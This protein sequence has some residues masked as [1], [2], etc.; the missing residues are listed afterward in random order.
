MVSSQG[1]VQDMLLVD[2]DV[3]IVCERFET[4]QGNGTGVR[5]GSWDGVQGWGIESG[6]GWR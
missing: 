5:Y 4:R 1:L 3:D 2:D 6:M